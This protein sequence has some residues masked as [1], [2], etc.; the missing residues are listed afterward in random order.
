MGLFERGARCNQCSLV[1]VD[2][3]N[4]LYLSAHILGKAG[5]FTIEGIPAE[6]ARN[7]IKENYLKFPCNIRIEEGVSWLHFDVLPQYGITQRVYGF[8]A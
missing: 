5:D 7:M 8:R 3:R 4:S 6:Q 1:K 2:H